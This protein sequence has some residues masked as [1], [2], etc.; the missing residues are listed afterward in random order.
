MYQKR[1]FTLIE[2]LVVVLIIGILAAVALPQ[3]E[4]AVGKSRI[5]KILPF[6]SSVKA[7]QEI[8]YMSNGNYAN[9]WAELDVTIPNGLTPYACVSG[10][11]KTQCVRLSDDTVCQLRSEGGSLYCSA[12]NL[13]TIGINYDHMNNARAFGLHLCLASAGSSQEKICKA[14]GGVLKSSGTPR[15]YSF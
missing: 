12:N 3:Y 7:A 1:G 2:L 14:L 8:Y 9:D 5:A 11:G 10:S 13:P 4:V 15:Y 6:L